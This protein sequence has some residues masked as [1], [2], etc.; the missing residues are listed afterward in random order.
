MN[1]IISEAHE[2]SNS[3]FFRAK[4]ILSDHG[5]GLKFAIFLIYFQG[6]STKVEAGS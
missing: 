2:I 4:K 1:L 3:S 6:G 5:I